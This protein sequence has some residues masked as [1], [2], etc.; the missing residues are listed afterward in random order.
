[1]PKRRRIDHDHLFKELLGAFFREFLELFVPD[2]AAQLRP[3]P[4]VFEDKETFDDLLT[5]H[6]HV[7]DLVA[8]VRLRGGAGEIHVH[9]EP[10]ARW[11]RVFS[12]RMFDYGAVLWLRRRLPVYP[13]AVLSFP[14]PRKPQPDYFDI[15]LP[16][17]HVLRFR[18]RVVHLGALDWRDFE[19]RENPV[20]AALMARMHI[21]PE[22]RPHVRLACLRL[23]ARLDLDDAHTA[24][25]TGFVSTYLRLSPAE[26]TLFEREAARVPRAERKKV[27]QF[28]GI[29]NEETLAR[30]IAQGRREGALSIVHALLKNH[31]RGSAQRRAAVDRLDVRGLQRLAT[32]AAGFESAEQLDRWLARKRS[33][34]KAR[35]TAAKKK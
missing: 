21:A 6:R 25:L 20:A 19:K 18:Y 27:M 4:I 33:T 17:L 31:L 22:E 3:G 16:G 26:Q 9:L 35:A 1:M 8:R 32:A 10:Q 14:R 2:L 29:W 28:D 11:Q 7:M 24:L 23:I 30:G 5:G 15:E 13:I 12:Q 34:A